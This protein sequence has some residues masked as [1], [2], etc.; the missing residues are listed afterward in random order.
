M[1]TSPDRS[2]PVRLAAGAL[3]LAVLPTVAC[4]GGGGA[5]T[6]DAG[7]AAEEEPAPVLVGV[8]TRE[9]IEE[10]EPAWVARTVEAEVD[11]E[12]A[13]ALA[14]VEPGAELTI[15][16]GTWCGDSRREV[17]RFWKALDQLGQVGSQIPFEIEYVAVD[18]KKEEPVERTGPVDLRYVP[19]F[20]VRRGG[21]EVGRVVE[22][23]PN[24]I[25]SDL[26]ALLTG[27]AAGTLTLRDDL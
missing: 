9:A 14:A 27:E 21:E 16:L 12:A 2:T 15:L 1:R 17:S 26:L 4:A 11:A 5:V 22:S 3:V 7:A 23:S 25:E 13:A 10:A 24:G 8:T 19:T 6:P 20:I 18:R